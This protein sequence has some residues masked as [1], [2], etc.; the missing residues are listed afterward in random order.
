MIRINLL[1]EQFRPVKKSILPY[2]LAMVV[3]VLGLL[4]IVF[5][6]L[7]LHQKSIQLVIQ[8]SNLQKEYDSP[9]ELKNED[10]EFITLSGVVN[11]Y[12]KL[13]KKK[14]DLEKRVA[15]IQEILSDRIIWSENLFL[16]ANLTPENVWYDRIRVTW[17]TF[18]EKVIKI[19]QKTGKPVIDPKTKDPQ[20]EQKS[21]KKPILEITGYVIS[22]EQGERQ[23][24]P[25][26]ENTTDPEKASYFVKQ[27]TLLRPKIEDTEFNGFSVRKFTL[28]YLIE[29][30]PGVKND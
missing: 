7:S 11:E 14:Q 23:I 28:E 26:I 8:K 16:L 18:R 19:D 5:F 13:D 29:A 27:F 4:S 20:F 25:L 2:F 12:R 15:V 30:K 17:Q 6:Y 21:V 22:G 24:S 9:T 3:F 1:P 10:G